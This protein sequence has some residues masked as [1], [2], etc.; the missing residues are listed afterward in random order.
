[1]TRAFAALLGGCLAAACLSAVAQDNANLVRGGDFENPAANGIPAGWYRYGQAGA[2]HRATLV[3]GGRTGK[4]V[5][6][7]GE[8]SY[9]GVASGRVPLDHSGAYAARAWARIPADAANTAYVKVDYF[10]STGKYLGESRTKPSVRAAGDTWQ[11]LSLVAPG[12]LYDEAT[13]IAVAVGVNQPGRACFDDVE[14]LR[15]EPEENLLP[16]GGF[17]IVA[18]DAPS[19]WGLGQAQGGTVRKVRRSVPVKEGWSCL[20]LVG[21]AA[22]TSSDAS[23]ALPLDRSKKYTLTGWARARVGKARIK[24]NYMKDGTWLGHITSPDAAG[25][26]WEK[27]T[28]VGDSSRYPEANRISA[29]A[30]AS[31]PEVDALFDHFV[32]RAE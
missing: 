23:G 25:N 4:C 16:D 31:G 3:D 20:Q 5:Q 19:S 2:P 30:N 6:V 26:Q 24:I 7:E 9:A 15:R 32:L 22:W 18:G 14:L 11:Y 13:Q 10:D 27:L 17:E 28:V 29:G 8:G 21:R 12:N 1:M